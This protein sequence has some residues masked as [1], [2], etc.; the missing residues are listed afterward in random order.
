MGNYQ[1]NDIINNL[2]SFW[3]LTVTEIDGDVTRQPFLEWMEKW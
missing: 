2:R 1:L 3:G